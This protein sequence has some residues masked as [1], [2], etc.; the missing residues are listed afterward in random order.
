MCGRYAI[1][2]PLEAIIEAFGVKNALS[3]L[4]PRYNTAPSQDLPVLRAGREGQELTLM[5][6]GWL[7]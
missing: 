1:T 3:S 2:S 5:R 6:W 4:R 7:C